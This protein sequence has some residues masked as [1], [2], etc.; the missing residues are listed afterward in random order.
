MLVRLI[1]GSSTSYDRAATSPGIVRR[2]GRVVDSEHTRGIYSARVLYL[3]HDARVFSYEPDPDNVACLRTNVGDRATVHNIAIGFDDGVA[4]LYPVPGQGGPQTTVPERAPSR[5]HYTDAPLDVEKVSLAKV[6]AEAE[7]V[8]PL[9]IDVEGAEYN[10]VLNSRPV[11]FD[12][13]DRVV[14][15]CD[16]PVPRMRH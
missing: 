8:D 3:A 7:H 1:S 9:K 14:L 16:A 15:E 12:G 4:T 10:L 11:D 5:G 2:R 13:V 6:I